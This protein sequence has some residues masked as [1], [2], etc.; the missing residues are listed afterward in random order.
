MKIN[1]SI[2]REKEQK[3]VLQIAILI[4]S[5]FAVA[6]LINEASSFDDGVKN[7]NNNLDDRVNI[8]GI[9]D[10]SLINNNGLVNSKVNTIFDNVVGYLIKNLNKKTFGIVSAEETPSL[11]CCALTSNGAVCQEM[12]TTNSAGCSTELIP[13][14]CDQVTQCK[15]GCCVDSNQGLCSTR[16]TNQQCTTNGGSWN[17]DDSCL[18]QECVKGCCVLGNNVQFAT[19]RRCEVISQVQG[20]QKDFR[21]TQTELECLALKAS[22]EKGACVFASSSSGNTGSSNEK[23]SCKFESEVECLKSG[24]RFYKDSLCSNPSLNTKCEK[25]KTVSCVEGE[26]EIYWFDSCG[27]KENIYN[28]NKDV[29][30]NNGRILSKEQS[31]NPTTSNAGST[32]C[33]NCNYL[34]GSKCSPS[35]EAS[36]KKVEDGNYI[37]KNANCVDS[38]GN[39]RKNGESWCIYD[40]Y[41]GEG[42]DT[43]GSRHWKEICINGEVKPEPCA[44]YRGQICVQSKI[45]ENGKTFTQASCVINRAMECISYNDNK[46]S[47]EESCNKNSQCMIK[48]INVDDYFKFSFCTPQYP[49]GFDISNEN[50]VNSGQ[51]VCAIANAKCTVIYQKGA[52]GKWK[53]VDN[54]D[55]EKQKF[56][57]QMNDL[58]IS[59]GDCGS[60]INYIGEGTNNIKVSKGKVVSWE[61]Y[62]KYA[63]P[64]EGQFADVGNMTD[65]LNAI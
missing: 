32:S 17:D 52:T 64:V 36:G 45:E 28:S 59:M 41:I 14:R 53:C 4:I 55:C 44:D 54:C 24:G 27:N 63:N 46:D 26:D 21:G 20:F 31:C 7:F 3:V 16:S 33:G 6:Y 38:K 5:Y 12:P 60:Y 35:T 50:G 29:S 9:G 42:K 2:K 34:L 43:V 62:K 30:W 18:I 47:M 15:V 23:S 49:R 19:E 40:S 25:Q 11:G 51:Q 61:S 22:N 13:S 10:N 65:Y 37:C 8:N 56:A 39:E 57:E 48:N 58:C 1:F